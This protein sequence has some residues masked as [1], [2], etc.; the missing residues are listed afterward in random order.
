MN[1]IPPNIPI[2]YGKLFSPTKPQVTLDELKAIRESWEAAFGRYV[3][4]GLGLNK[5][6]GRMCTL[7]KHARIMPQDIRWTFLKPEFQAALDRDD[8]NSLI[9]LG[10][11]L[12]LKQA[13]YRPPYNRVHAFIL[14]N[15]MPE[16]EGAKGGMYPAGLC[17]CS[18][19]LIQK[20]LNAVQV[21]SKE[22]GIDEVKQAIR[23]MKLIRMPG[24][25]FTSFKKDK[26]LYMLS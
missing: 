15:W 26:E 18:S 14:V 4:D 23:R 17:Y 2:L 7:H 11:L 6:R 21:Q 13:Q 20:L 1:F 19:G 16:S 3:S 24:K 22:V 12:A 8:C 5:V 25:H 9:R 10:Q